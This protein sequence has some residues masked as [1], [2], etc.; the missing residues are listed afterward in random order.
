VEAGIRDVAA[1]IDVGAAWSEDTRNIVVA[2]LSA[3]FSKVVGLSARVT[4]SNVQ[5]TIFS[6][7]P[8]SFGMSAAQVEAGTIELGLQD[9]GGFDLVLAQIARDQGTTPDEARRTMIG[10]LR[11]LSLVT[12]ELEIIATALARQIENH[13]KTLSIVLTPKTRVTVLQAMEGARLD[14]LNLL[15]QFNVEAKTDR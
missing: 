14:P 4:L 8:L 6:P 2:P 10:M 7:N 11:A 12:P 3:T 5:S 13:G 1:D 9:L 15:A